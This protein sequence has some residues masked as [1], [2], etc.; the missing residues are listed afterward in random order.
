MKPG[1]EAVFFGIPDGFNDIRIE[2][3]FS[4]MSQI[5]LEGKRGGFIDDFSIKIKIHISF[6]IFGEFLIGTHDALQITVAGELYP[7]PHRKVGQVARL[8]SEM[9]E[10]PDQSLPVL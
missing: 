4:S 9:V 6:I 2:E 10:K 3:G 7:Q 5:D 8:L 1:E